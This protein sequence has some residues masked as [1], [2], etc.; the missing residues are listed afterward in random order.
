VPDVVTKQ[1]GHEPAS[2]RLR[3]LNPNGDCHRHT[4][5]NHHHLYVPR[6]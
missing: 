1:F 4:R 6:L 3:H 5:P 2:I